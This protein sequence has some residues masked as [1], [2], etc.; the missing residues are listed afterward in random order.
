MQGQ[1]GHYIHVTKQGYEQHGISRNETFEAFDYSKYR[2]EIQNRIGANFFASSKTNVEQL[3]N[4]LNTIFSN[5]QVSSNVQMVRDRIEE[6]MKE[7]F[8]DK[9]GTIDWSKGNVYTKQQLAQDQMRLDSLIKTHKNQ[10]KVQLSTLIKRIQNLETLKDNIQKTNNSKA[11][12]LQQEINQIYRILIEILHSFKKDIEPE[13]DLKDINIKT[14]SQ[15]QGCLLSLKG[16]TDQKVSQVSNLINTINEVLKRYNTRPPINLQKG[17]L[18][19][20]AIAFAPAVAQNVAIEH[21]EGVLEGL[22]KT[23]KGDDRQQVK[24]NLDFFTKDL[25]QTLKLHHYSKDETGN[26]LVS[27]L[28]SQGKIDV[29]L[30]WG[31]GQ[32]VP[33]SAKNVRLSSGYDIHILSKSSLLYLIQDE[34]SNFVNHYLNIIAEHEGGPVTDPKCNVTEAHKTMEYVLIFKAFTGRTFGRDMATVFM[35]NDNSQPGGIRIF[36]MSDLIK[37]AE[38]ALEESIFSVTAND[39]PIKQLSNS[40]DNNRVDGDPSSRI[41]NFLQ[42]VHGQKIS[43]SFNPNF[44]R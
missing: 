24:I 35:V 6:I 12:D 21:L 39:K 9:M 41:A 15:I 43:V 1:I 5:K 18:F 23:K 38:N 26:F 3:Q 32:T 14:I 30:E 34:N 44:L 31:E 33:V 7:K 10:Q 17:D 19:E 22:A 4:A 16:E 40:I 11:K 37:R 8:Q 36:D 25:Q 20:L 29:D 13:I 28:A 42:Q 27:S 2:Q